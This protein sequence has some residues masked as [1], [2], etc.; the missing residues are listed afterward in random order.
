VLLWASWEG[1]EA[2]VAATAD[3]VVPGVIA[4]ALAAAGVAIGAGG[5]WKGAVVPVTLAAALAGTLLAD[6]LAGRR[7]RGTVPAAMAALS[8]AATV[9]LYGSAVTGLCF[10]RLRF[11]SAVLLLAAPL[12]ASLPAA[13]AWV[14][15]ESPAERLL[16]STRYRVALAAVPLLAVLGVA[17]GDA[18][19]F[20]GR[21]SRP[22]RQVAAAGAENVRQCQPSDA[23]IA[24]RA[25]PRA[26]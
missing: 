20:R 24:G 1:I 17:R 11:E 9:A 23:P 12:L 5:W 22:A 6:A 16:R 2:Q 15:P 26:S 19:A 4:A 21:L 7:G 3:R 10:G 18:E 13:V 8:G 25:S 14:L